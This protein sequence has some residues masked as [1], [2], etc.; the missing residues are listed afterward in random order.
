MFVAPDLQVNTHSNQV[1]LPAASTVPNTIPRNLM[2]S[3][4]TVASSCSTFPYLAIECKQLVV[5]NN[6]TIRPQME[7]LIIVA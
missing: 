6:Q 2:I 3:I 4:L 1:E 5:K 7:L